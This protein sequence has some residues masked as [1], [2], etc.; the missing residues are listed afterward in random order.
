VTLACVVLCFGA[1]KSG[2]EDNAPTNKG[3]GAKQHTA[4]A[5]KTLGGSGPAPKKTS[6]RATKKVAPPAQDHGYVINAGKRTE[7]KGKDFL[8]CETVNPGIKGD[9]NIMAKLADG[10]KF[11]LSG[12]IN[13]DN[14]ANHRGLVLGEMPNEVRARKL[15]LKL[16]GRTLSGKAETKAGPIEFSFEC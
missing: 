10:T 6:P 14:S 3:E 1:C 13:E 4:S 7:L 15:E 11:R 8:I 16:E 9:F 2:D 5:K 12:N